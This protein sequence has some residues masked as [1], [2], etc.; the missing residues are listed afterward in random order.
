MTEQQARRLLP[1]TVVYWDGNPKDFGTVTEIGLNGFY[2]VW[3]DGQSGWIAYTDA[4]KVK[5]F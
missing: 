2:V 3:E 1:M 5:I 4:T